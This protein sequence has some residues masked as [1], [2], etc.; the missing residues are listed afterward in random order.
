MEWILQPEPC[1]PGPPAP[2]IED[3]LTSA[4][5]VHSDMPM[6]WLRRALILSEEVITNTALATKGQ[7]NNPMWSIIRKNRITASNFGAVLS[8]KRRQIT[9]SLKKRR[10]SSYNLE[11]VKAVAWGITHEEHALK[12]YEHEFSASV[13]QTGIWLHES[14]VLGASPDG[15]VLHPPTCDVNFQT[16]EARDAV[17]DIV[18]VKCPYSAA[19]LTI[20]E[21][22]HSLKDFYL[23]YR[24]GFFYLKSNHPYF[25]QIQGQLH[26]CNKNCCDLIVWTTKDCKIIR[27]TKDSEWTKNIAQLIEFYFNTFIPELIKN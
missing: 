16:P 4:E 21:A 3:L 24:E 2:I 15:L 20:Y 23:E 22:V 8:T 17:P 9:I 25:H 14:G 19:H 5:F 13:Q 11:S 7:R 1:E 12:K 27:I 26:L 10:M 18:E 6:V